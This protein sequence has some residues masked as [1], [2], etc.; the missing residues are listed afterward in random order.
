M[1]FLLLYACAHASI[2]CLHRFMGVKVASCTSSQKD[3]P[4]PIANCGYV[5]MDES[6]WRAPTRRRPQSGRQ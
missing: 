1:T 6:E 4:V 5:S 2:V 3:P